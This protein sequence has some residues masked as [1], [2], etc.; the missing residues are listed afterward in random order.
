M[1]GSEQLKE[2]ERTVRAEAGV[3]WVSGSCGASE[4]IL[5][6]ADFKLSAGGSHGEF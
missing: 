2:E 4:A 3:A 5:S 6:S 1:N